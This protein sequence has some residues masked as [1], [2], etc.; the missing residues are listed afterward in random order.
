MNIAPRLYHPAPWGW[1]YSYQAVLITLRLFDLASTAVGYIFFRGP[2]L[3]AWT[4]LSV[5]KNINPPYKGLAEVLAPPKTRA[6]LTVGGGQLGTNLDLLKSVPQASE[7]MGTFLAGVKPPPRRWSVLGC[8]IRGF[9]TNMGPTMIKLGQI[10]S[11]REEV[12]PS[13]RKELQGLQDKLPAMPWTQVKSILERELERPIEEVFEYVEEA[14]IAAASLSQV[15]RAKL[16][17]EQQEVAL[18]VQRPYLQGITTLDTIIICDIFF[19][20]IKLALPLF[21]KSTDIN[22]FAVSFRDSLE[23]EIDFS[24]EVSNQDKYYDLVMSHSIYRQTNKIA[25]PYHKYCT[26]KLITMELVKNYYRLDRI[27]DELTPQQLLE[28]ASTK[29]EGYG[30]EV[31]LPLIYAQIGLSVDGL[32]RWGFSHGDF[33]LGNIYALAPEKEGDGWKV[34]ICDFGMMVDLDERERLHALA[35]LGDLSYFFN[36][37]IT[38]E[39]FVVDSPTPVSNRTR[40]KFTSVMVRMIKRNCVRLPGGERHLQLRAQMRGTST[41]VASDITYQAA[42]LGIHANPFSWLLLKNFSYAANI[43]LTMSTD[44]DGVRLLGGNVREYIKE[45]VIEQLDK[46]D[47]TNLRKSLPEVLKYLAYRD[48]EEILK[49]LLTGEKVKV[50][51]PEGRHTPRQDIRFDLENLSDR[52]LS[53]SGQAQRLKSPRQR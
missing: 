39:T 52:E 32:L 5:L 51:A 42:A 20:L 2:L 24:V 23:G 19:G 34:F 17:L 8:F 53:L 21:R 49:A 22:L 7:L 9:F 50:T 12:P 43:G 48:R 25:R 14:P 10:L 36:G 11:M 46:R 3:L 44:W 4:R 1:I 27:M 37:K 6:S 28:F 38:A 29:V 45:S 30:P 40:Q 47:I 33:H 18:K 26:S 41:N 13:V 31:S 16:R 15:H 35:F